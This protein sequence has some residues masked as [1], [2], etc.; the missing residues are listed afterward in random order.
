MVELV[1][2]RLQL[3]GVASFQALGLAAVHCGQALAQQRQGLQGQV[4]LHRNGCR[5]AQRQNAQRDEQHLGEAMQG[6]GQQRA[7]AR[8]H[9]AQWWCLLVGQLQAALHGQQGM[10]LAVL[11]GKGPEACAWWGRCIGQL[12]HLVPQRARARQRGLGLG[13]QPVDLPIQA[14]QRLRQA[15]IGGHAALVDAVRGLP[16]HGGA[17]LIELH[18]QL[19]LQLL[20][21]VVLEQGAQAP[22][23]QCDGQ[24]HPGQHARQQAQAQGARVH[25]AQPGSTRR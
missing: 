19:G 23:D 18:R 25:S 14:R 22:P 10:A 24:Q 1:D 3:L 5:Q 17:Q 8:H 7:V 6:L 12:Q 16:V 2:Q 13:P 21:D 15:W 11:Q 4:Q 20:R 9:Q